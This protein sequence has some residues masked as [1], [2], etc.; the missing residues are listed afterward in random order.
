LLFSV[1]C[2]RF[3]RTSAMCSVVGVAMMSEQA[4]KF[5]GMPAD[6]SL[7]P[8]DNKCSLSIA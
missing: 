7:V 5:S 2:A 3:S 4:F 1:E 6:Q 8:G